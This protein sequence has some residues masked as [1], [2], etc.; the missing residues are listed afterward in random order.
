MDIV[1]IFGA[2]SAAQSDN[3]HEFTDA[4]V[5]KV[6]Q[7]GINGKLAMGNPDTVRL[8]EDASERANQD[9]EYVLSPSWNEPHAEVEVRLVFYRGGLCAALL[10]HV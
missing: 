2:P 4:V 5:K 1:A 6:V 9:T 8:S 3:G 10:K 7:C